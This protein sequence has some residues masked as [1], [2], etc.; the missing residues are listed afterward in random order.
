MRALDRVFINRVAK[1]MGD[2]YN[3]LMALYWPIAIQL[4]T[5]AM[6]A[7][8]VLK[9]R[10]SGDLKYGL[11]W[12]SPRT[13]LASAQGRVPIY[14]MAVFSLFDQLNAAMTSIPQTYIPPA[15]Q[16]A[17]T[18]TVVLFTAVIAYFYLGSRFKQVHYAGCVLVLLACITGSV[19]E[20][21]QGQLPPPQNTQGDA[22]SVATST[23]ALMYTVFLLAQAP[24]GMSSCYKQKV[25]KLVDMDLMWATWWS[26]NF[27]I[28]W[29]IVFYSINWIPY[30]IPGGHN[31][32][33][34][35]SLGSDLSDAW[36]C[37]TGSNPKGD[38]TTC[39]EDSAWFWFMIYLLFNITFNVLMLW[40]TKY[41]SATWASIGNVLCG[42]LYGVFGQFSF[43]SGAGS[44]LMSLEEWLAL[45]YSSVAMWVYNIEDEVDQNG[46]IVYGIPKDAEKSAD[47]ALEDAS[48][49]NLE[50]V[51]ETEAIVEV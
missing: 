17:L 30:P 6:C 32:K 33:S 42:D 10:Y 49:S 16:T 2:Y 12:F 45:S 19:V 9:K 29:G 7:V 15:M 5:A 1:I 44:K 47:G 36:K 22:V 28:V 21:Q 23:M 27:Q 18:N 38:V 41:L 43:V 46:E 31:E 26:G 8:Y 34:P 3:T 14:T 48:V 51:V 25:M 20:L 24:A 40:L 50:H 35:V 4:M 13:P 39:G 37:F 11:A